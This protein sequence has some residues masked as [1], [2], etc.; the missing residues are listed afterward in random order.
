MRLANQVILHISDLHFSVKADK[1][2]I[3]DRNLLFNGLIER[4][5]KIEPEW[6]PTLVCVTGDITDKGQIEGYTEAGEWFKKFSDELNVDIGRFLLTPGNHDCIRD[7]Q[8]CSNLI[9]NTS[10]EADS[11]LKCDIPLYLQKRFSSFSEFCKKIG[12]KPYKFGETDSYLVGNREVDGIQFVSL[13]TSWFSWKEKEEGKLWLGLEILRYLESKK[14][15]VA[16]N[17]DPSEKISIALMHHGTTK[18][19]HSEESEDHGGR[20]PS[21]P[22][23]WK[24]SHLALYG[25]SHENA[26]DDPDLQK[27][28]CWVVRAGATNAGANFPNNVNL[29]RLSNTG[30]ELKTLEYNSAD[31]GALWEKS[32]A[33]KSYN[34]KTSG[35]Q[36][37][38][39]GI[40]S[41]EQ[42]EK[43]LELIRERA[44]KFASEVIINKSRQ[45]KP[46][47][48]LPEQ[49][50]LHVEI[51]PESE[52]DTRPFF[53]GRSK[54]KPKLSSMP[55][56]EAVFRSRLTIL[57]GDLGAGK[58][59]LLAK[60]TEKI[61][62]K[63]PKCLPLFVPAP[64]LEISANDGIDKLISQIDNFIST[65]LNAGGQWSY[66]Q[67]LDEGYEI[68][69]LADGLDEIN[70]KSAVHLIRLLANL[71]LVYSRV[72]VVLSSRFS[73]VTGINFERW[74]ICQ[75]AQIDASQKELLFKNEALA[76]GLDD[77]KSSMIAN[78]AKLA[79]EN[80]PSLNTIAN[81][82]LAVR[83]L[84]PSII[85]QSPLHVERTLG[86][87]LYE[88]LLQRLG[89][90][91]EKDVKS[92]PLAEFEAAFPT[93]EY[94]AII[95]GEL[96]F[97]FL[98]QSN[99][100]RNKATEIIKKLIPENKRTYA[101]LIAK[102]FLI[103]LEDTGII[104]G[105]EN[106]NFIY[107]PLTQISA[108]VYLAEKILQDISIETL[109][110]E[111][112]RVVSFAGTMIR[113]MYRIDSV[114]DW[115][116]GCIIIW[117][118]D[119]SGIT[120]SCYETFEFS[121]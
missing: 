5:K 14:Q 15:L 70:K 65:D 114:R 94:R 98:E 97:H 59:T 68:L 12:I 117:M 22:Y 47:G 6:H 46:H 3:A 17:T 26:L 2:R 79:L 36:Q 74:Q 32:S 31:A 71:P 57:F 50:P 51:K 112:W 81:T 16:V 62:E 56:D 83:L 9:P 120:P 111:S 54:D 92:T 55:I 73:E 28:H 121:I 48:N 93:P 99:L 104:V 116:I 119:R 86:D 77:T 64:R 42:H 76:Q 61:G 41:T 100:S 40:S 95:M 49:I 34:W 43:S 29:I 60:L 78:K 39:T 24:R 96:A 106:I 53:P 44:V 7:L 27:A 109:R 67:V 69:L 115:F 4:L 75:V 118:K 35:I 38:T 18:Y 82:P 113:R 107:Q 89:D 84:Y 8:I 103:F 90:W 30:F 80:N 1:Q 91:A 37:P 33:A 110:I 102:Q 108:G 85:A 58:S 101:D 23:L 72:T 25:H 87:L 11:L 20:A 88:L 19:F 63:V 10:T 45:I 66:K 21:L 105:N 13:N 52:S